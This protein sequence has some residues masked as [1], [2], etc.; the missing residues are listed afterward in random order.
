MQV[1]VLKSLADID[2]SA[3]DVLVGDH[4]FLSHGFLHGLEATDCLAPQGWYSQHLAVYD[5]TRLVAAMP[6][7]LRDNSFGEFVFDWS[8]AEAYERSGGRYYPKLVSAIPFSPVTGPRVLIAAD[9]AD[10]AA[11]AQL[12]I[13]TARTACDDNR[14]SSWH[15]LFPAT[16]ELPAYD[17]A[18]LARRLGCQYHWFNQDYRD[19][20]HFLT[21]LNSK[22]RKMIKRERRLV[23]EQ[24]LAIEVLTGDQISAEHWTVF[25][26]FYCSTFA[27]KWGEPRL[28]EAF[29]Q[30]LEQ[31]LPGA[32]VLILARD[33][34][35]YVAGACALKSKHTVYG[36]HWG[37]SAQ[38]DNLHFELCYYQTI[39]YC[40]EHGLTTLD[41]GA[42][43]E[44][45]L[46][47]GFV[48]V[49]T[50]SVHW[51]REPRFRQAV[52]DFLKRERGAM[53]HHLHAL[54]D[55]V[56]FRQE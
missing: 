45:K 31:R 11:L 49:P 2:A 32:A 25:H 27:R 5:G 55:H 1:V 36:R 13:E 56:A 42:Q 21:A 10:R 40:I 28:T 4:P 8:W 15:C 37:C 23:T 7:Y 26:R 6:L 3:W 35:H 19:F 47:R 17:A 14:L 16:E 18:G 12:L 30:S 44:H 20:D 34:G 9:R 46:A 51:I 53:E 22:K 41:A 54:E 38:F 33:R 50:W 24:A 39:A 52:T 48:P 29:F 43:G